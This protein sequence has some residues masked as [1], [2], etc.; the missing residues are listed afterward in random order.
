M[1]HLQPVERGDIGGFPPGRKTE[2]FARSAHIRRGQSIGKHIRPP[3]ADQ[4]AKF[5]GKGRVAGQ[6]L[7]SAIK[8]KRLLRQLGIKRRHHQ[9]GA[10]GDVRIHHRR[11]ESKTAG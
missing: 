9:P 5:A 1:P 6:R 2:K 8:L 10:A 7:V 3:D 11:H 4:H